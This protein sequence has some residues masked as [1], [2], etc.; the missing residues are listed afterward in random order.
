MNEQTGAHTIGQARCTSFRARIYNEST[1]DPSFAQTRQSSCPST[2][3]SGD[4]N[5]APLDLQTPTC[6]D[7]NYFK[8]LIN[9]KGLLHSDQQLFSG[10]STNALVQTYSNNPNRFNLDF[11]AAMIKMGDI[12]PLT[13]SSGEIRNNCRKTN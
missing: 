1:I 2:S 5:L 12:S 9:Q 4:N 7:N 10:G 8:N 13:G 11:A 6:F 3:G